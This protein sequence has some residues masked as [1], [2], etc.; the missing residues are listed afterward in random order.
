MT[1]KL[2]MD[3]HRK[4]VSCDTAAGDGQ[5]QESSIVT[6]QLMIGRYRK[7]LSCDTAAGD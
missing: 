6:Q 3:R 4:A 1:Q 5:A 7:A 2:V